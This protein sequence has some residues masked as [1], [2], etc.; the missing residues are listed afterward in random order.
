[1]SATRY[2]VYNRVT[3]ERIGSR[4]FGSMTE[5]TLFGLGLPPHTVTVWEVRP[6]V[7]PETREN[8]QDCPER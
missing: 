2:E 7:G 1:M 6:I 4:T 3:G 5:A 8:G